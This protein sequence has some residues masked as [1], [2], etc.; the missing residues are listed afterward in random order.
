[1]VPVLV[2]LVVRVGVGVRGV[3]L[4]AVAVQVRVTLDVQLA[5]KVGVAEVVGT[6]VKLG[7]G[8]SPM[9]VRSMRREGNEWNAWRRASLRKR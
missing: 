9:R 2:Q 4:E 8:G 1:M 5:V 6:T 7:V 3:E